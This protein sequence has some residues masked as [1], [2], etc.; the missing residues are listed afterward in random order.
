[1]NKSYEIRA[2]WY[3]FRSHSFWSN[4]GVFYAPGA[5]TIGRRP[6]NTLVCN[7]ISVSG[8]PR[9]VGGWWS[10]LGIPDSRE[11]HLPN[12]ITN[13]PLT[14]LWIALFCG[15][16]SFIEFQS[17]QFSP[18]S[19]VSPVMLAQKPSPNIQHEKSVML[20]GLFLERHCEISISETL[21][22]SD[23][24]TN[25]ALTAYASTKWHRKKSEQHTALEN[26]THSKRYWTQR[27]SHESSFKHCW[28]FIALF[29]SSVTP[30]LTSQSTSM[31]ELFVFFFPSKGPTSMMTVSSRDKWLS[32]SVGDVIAL[33]KPHP[34]GPGAQT[35]WTPKIRMDLFPFK[36]KF[37]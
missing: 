5:V 21:K 9:K 25:G 35:K 29:V 17:R 32:W 36:G 15:L 20:G 3:S 19:W 14:Y 31:D 28:H 1:M 24:S 26:K 7:D 23:C 37:F 16:D 12:E 2:H 30:F 27:I 33:T 34:P 6:N 10:S 22:I 11:Y 13:E 18:T 4:L 8:R